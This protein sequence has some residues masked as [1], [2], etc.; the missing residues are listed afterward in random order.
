MSHKLKDVADNLSTTAC[1]F[2][3]HAEDTQGVEKKWHQD[4]CLLCAKAT[5]NADVRLSVVVC[6]F[7][8]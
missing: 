3:A 6:G 7:L 4:F 5:G 8:C 1:D 2:D